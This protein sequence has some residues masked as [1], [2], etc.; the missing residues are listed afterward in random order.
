MGKKPRSPDPAVAEEDP[1]VSADGDSDAEDASSSQNAAVGQCKHAVKA[2]KLASF[3]GQLKLLPALVE[4]KRKTAGNGSSSAR[5]RSGVAASAADASLWLCTLCGT[6]DAPATHFTPKHPVGIDLMTMQPRCFP[7]ELALVDAAL[8]PKAQTKL[9][10]ALTLIE[11]VL[12]S[13]AKKQSAASTATAIKATAA[14]KAA[15]VASEQQAATAVEML[16]S[17]SASSAPIVKGLRNLGN[18]WSVQLEDTAVSAAPR[19][20]LP[21]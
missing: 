15:A 5:N 2:V 7:C 12:Q 13:S 17:S 4:A 16:T 21:Q 14:S 6:V 10:P 18:T 20:V 19:A 3:R 8:P 1:S 9:K 11:H